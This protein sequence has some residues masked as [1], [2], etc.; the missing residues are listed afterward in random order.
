MGLAQEEEPVFS[1][2]DA[3]STTDAHGRTDSP[4]HPA[5]AYWQVTVRMALTDPAPG[6]HVQMLLPLSDGRQSV[7]SRQATVS[8]ASYREEADGLN[9][10]GHWV[11]NGVSNAPRQLIYEY[12]VQIADG[13]TE[14]PQASFPPKTVPLELRRSLSPSR[15]IQ[16]NAASI[17]V[18]ARRI[19]QGKATLNQAVRALYDEVAAL[20]AAQSGEGGK[21]DALAVL[22]LQRGG[23]A[24]KTRALVALLRAVGIPARIVGGIQLGDTATKR[25]TISWVEAWLD[26]A[27]ISMDPAGGHFAWLPNTYLALYRNDL[28]LLI[29][30]K[31]IP[32]EYMFDIR[33][34]TRSEA[35]A[36]TQP[37]PQKQR[38]SGVR[39][40]GDPLH[41]IAA[42]VDRPL[43]NVVLVNEGDIP[44][45]MVDR[46]L[47]VARDDRLNVAVL[48]VDSEPSHS[49]EHYLQTLVS[50]N[51][52]LIREADL[53]LINTRDTAGFHA[54][55]K[56]GETGIVLEDLRI[57]MAG[58]FA[59]PVGKVLGAVLLG[60]VK[61]REIV[62]VRQEPDLARLWEMARLHLREGISIADSAARFNVRTVVL[63]AETTARFSWWRRQVIRLWTLAV[64]AHVPLPALNFLLV[65]PLI[66]FFLVI[67]RNV[68]GLETFGSFSPMLLSLAFLTTGLGW[69]L[70]VF[71]IIVGLGTGLRLALQRL[72]LHLVS[73]VA[74]LIALVAV[75]M[76]GLTVLGAV[77]GVGALLHAGIFPMVIMANIIENFTNTQL[78]RGTAE[79]LRLTVS[80]LL[81][82]TCS[83]L[84]IEETGLK[85][86]V[87]TFPEMLAGVIGIEL[88]L[89][90]WRGLRLLEYVRFRELMRNPE[91][92]PPANAGRASVG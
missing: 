82:A 7:L 40:E 14:P 57:I 77:F 15:L 86:L 73:R 43:A 59:W 69:G 63:T 45:E 58:D 80:T 54:L 21:S 23:R 13:R 89:G 84:G 50:N 67:I 17:R 10:W 11:L 5:T 24:G 66:A 46:M 90:R 12:T 61:P 26:D 19:V 25:T 27:W 1:S 31:Q 41:T 85:S 74:I 2:E 36:S 9:L 88:L 65:L 64:Q 71:A 52:M 51:V 70:V 30:T 4:P 33:Q 18:R 42:Y 87:L 16:S 68:I 81:V 56:Q 92:P 6:S 29:H 34:M 20:P 44:R 47:A 32:V 55:L 78:E 22:T 8:G 75:S 38:R 62:L 79:A 49:R 39:Y 83:Y 72:R 37:Q 60:L 91:S 3:L 48:H 76:V 28:P 35:L 53:V